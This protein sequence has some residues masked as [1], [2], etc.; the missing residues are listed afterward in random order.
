MK[1]KASQYV[2]TL[3]LLI[4]LSLL[5]CTGS[6]VEFDPTKHYRIIG[7]ASPL[8]EDWSTGQIQV[9]HSSY[10]EKNERVVETLAEVESRDGT[11]E[12]IGSVDQP[13]V[14][15]VYA[16]I[17][18]EI[19]NMTPAVLETGAE[20]KVWYTTPIEGL[21]AE[22]TGMHERLVS[23]WMFS[24]EYRNASA[25]YT[26]VMLARR[27]EQEAESTSSS[28]DDDN[29]A[30][31]SSPAAQSNP[32]EATAQSLELETSP[33]I[34][35][36]SSEAQVEQTAEEKA[37][38]ENN[39]ETEQEEDEAYRL[40]QELKDIE[41]NVLDELAN[42]D[43]EPEVALLAFELGALG[44][45]AEAGIKRLDEL[46]TL[47]PAETVATRIT[48]RRAR[49][50]AYLEKSAANENLLVGDP[51]PA[52]S[53]PSL[54]GDSVSLAS[55]TEAN[56]VVL[57]DFWASWCGPC[58]KTFPHLKELY[59]EYRELGFEIVM[60]SIDDTQE[61]WQEASDEEELPWINLGDISKL[62][63]PVTMTYGVTFIPKG[64]IL[65]TDGTIIA[66]DISTEKLEELLAK[67]LATATPET[68]SE[69]VQEIDSS[70]DL[71]S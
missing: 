10:N 63:G 2:S 47:L 54:D 39:E 7:D 5:G 61:E 42:S 45:D 19:K 56:Q 51:A 59:T 68:K 3:C 4:T 69:T 11:F 36:D 38:A 65:D 66:K 58:I 24:E 6:K 20:I 8:S 17:D 57:L 43:E 62:D 30:A 31:A 29:T 27:A 33:Q 32:S 14:V 53:A 49:M 13:T 21:V 41:Y 71:G 50:V 48:P 44:R 70:K 64:Y 18:D 22:G 60:V 9:K 1:P 46:A 12:I 67:R 28:E 16:L 15:K 26:E 52:F 23:S 35:T 40:Y 37:L 25:A 55:V 34:S